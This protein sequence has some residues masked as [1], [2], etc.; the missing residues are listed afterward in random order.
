MEH[1]YQNVKGWFNMEIQY[2][3]LLDFCE[4]DS[5]FVELGAWKGKSTCFIATEISNKKPGVKFYTID[6]FKG[7]TDISNEIEIDVYNAED[8]DIFEQ[9]V[10]NIEPVKDYV[11]YIVSESHTAA[12]NFED[13]SVD[14]IF[15]DAGHSYEAVKNDIEK[16]L[17]K[18][19]PN[20]II[21]G[22]DYLYTW[23]GVIKA[24]DE[25]FGKPDKVENTC[26]F[27][28]IKNN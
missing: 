14:V 8:K 23:P 17:P 20:S 15:I 16:W 6:T 9:F 10:N 27:K 21:A 7:I 3:E 5:I 25:F 26:W 1:Y 13:G 2:Q 4:S 22:H 18:M 28:Y 12:Q 24:V 19:K 11:N